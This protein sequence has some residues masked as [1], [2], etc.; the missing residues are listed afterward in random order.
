MLAFLPPN[1]PWYSSR[2]QRLPLKARNS[3]ERRAFATMIFSTI[4]GSER[5]GAFSPLTSTE[6]TSLEIKYLEICLA[7]DSRE[8]RGEWDPWPKAT[9]PITATSDRRKKTVDVLIF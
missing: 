2:Y 3:A 9:P 1:N 4:S 5:L 6:S 7:D 8:T